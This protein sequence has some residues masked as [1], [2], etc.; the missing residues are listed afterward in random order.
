MTPGPE[1]EPEEY[2][3]TGQSDQGDRIGYRQ[4]AV[5]A[6]LIEALLI[7]ALLIEALLIE[8]LLI[9]GRRFPRPGLAVRL[10]RRT[11]VRCRSVLRIPPGPHIDTLHSTQSTSRVPCR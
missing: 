2:G 9:R 3:D 7:E 10:A 11:G 5:E 6:L 4:Y 8:A 1:Q